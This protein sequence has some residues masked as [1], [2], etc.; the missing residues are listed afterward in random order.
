[1]SRH[2]LARKNEITTSHMTVLFAAANMSLNSSVCVRTPTVAP[3]TAQAPLGK[4]V[5]MNPQMTATNNDNRDQACRQGQHMP[6]R[7]VRAMAHRLRS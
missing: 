1:M 6:G 2:T 7:K 5:R 4:G 3:K